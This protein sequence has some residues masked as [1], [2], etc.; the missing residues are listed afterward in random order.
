MDR[1]IELIIAKIKSDPAA[2]WDFA[3]LA[4]LVNLSPSRFRHL[5][6]QETGT[7]PAQYLKEVRVRRAAK[8]LRNTFLTIKQILKK[9]GLGSNA[10]FVRDFRKLFGITPTTYRR[11]IS[12]TTKRRRRRK[13]RYSAIPGKI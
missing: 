7:T 6:K 10:H 5:F 8:L 12:R 3:T 13:K 2:G 4:V 1:R 11:T 9:V